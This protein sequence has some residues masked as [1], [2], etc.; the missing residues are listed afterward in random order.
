VGAGSSVHGG[1]RER[2]VRLGG[3]TGVVADWVTVWGDRFAC[4]SRDEF[5]MGRFDPRPRIERRLRMPASIHDALLIRG[6]LFLYLGSDRLV[7]LDPD[8]PLAEPRDVVGADHGLRVVGLDS[9]G[10]SRIVVNLPG[11]PGGGR[12]VRGTERFVADE[13]GLRVVERSVGDP[14]HLANPPVGPAD[15]SLAVAGRHVYV[16][17]GSD[18]LVV[19]RDRTSEALLVPVTV[20][21]DFF[22]PLVIAVDP[23]DTVQWSNAFGFHNVYSCNPDQPGCGGFSAE[24][25]DNGPPAPGAWV[26]SRT[27]PQPGSNP[28][29]CQSHAPDMAGVVAVS[30]PDAGPPAVLDGRSGEPMSV[31]KADPRAASVRIS[32]DSA[33]C[34]GAIDHQILWGTRFPG[35]PGQSLLP[36]GSACSIGPSSPTVWNTPRLAVGRLLWWIVVATDSQATEGPWG[37]A[38]DGQERSGPAADGSSGECGV[39]VKDLSNTCGR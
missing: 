3:T 5:V 4:G 27:F 25:F 39:S 31:N 10:G 30:A 28:Y 24:S 32:W 2:F 38:S 34:P 8:D 19:Y 17:A 22:S 33:T 26:F 6:R 11:F 36:L 15:R 7:A 29:V 18:G 16:A 20:A 35:R 9:P 1:D 37:P 12:A 23:G 13:T 21:N 14:P